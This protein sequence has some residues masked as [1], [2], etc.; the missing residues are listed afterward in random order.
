MFAKCKANLLGILGQIRRGDH[1]VHLRH[2]LV[3]LPT[4]DVVPDQINP[5]A[6]ILNP[7]GPDQFLELDPH[8][9]P[10][11]SHGKPYEGSVFFKPPPVPLISEGL[12]AHD[13]H[14]G[15][16]SPAANQAG[17]S[18]RPPRFLYR[19][20]FVV[21]EH[22]AMYHVCSWSLSGRLRFGLLSKLKLYRKTIRFCASTGQ[23]GHLPFESWAPQ[24]LPGHA[25]LERRGKRCT[26]GSPLQRRSISYMEYPR[27]D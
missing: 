8:A 14:R 27:F 19:L 12:A 6:A 23:K 10:R 24:D 4:S 13:P 26:A 17:L 15:E 21:M 5:R 9:C 22:K 18:G 7:V 16:E 2:F 3:A 25:I 11:I 20:D 1:Q